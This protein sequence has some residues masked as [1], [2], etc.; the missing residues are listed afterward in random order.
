MNE[1]PEKLSSLLDDF[2][3]AQAEQKALNEA[4]GD[5]NQRYTLRRY[6]MIGEV[7]RQEMPQRIRPHFVADV[8]AQIE[9]EPALSVTQAGSK[10]PT[11]DSQAETKPSWLWSVLFKPLTGVAVAAA[12]AFVAVSSLQLQFSES[13]TGASDQLAQQGATEA[14]VEQLASL[15]ALNVPVSQVSVNGNR[16]TTQ[17][18]TSWKIRRGTPAFQQKLNTYLINHNEYSK[19]MQGIIPQVRVVG[20]D[21]QK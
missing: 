12:V 7:M 6:Q 21:A 4:L 8:M 15:P 14:R 1:Q 3:S 18:G 9:Q 19:S 17:A 16:A 11:R 10:T 2:H 5:I 13:G 20:F